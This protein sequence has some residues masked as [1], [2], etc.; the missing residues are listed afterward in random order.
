MD[1][2]TYAI[3]DPEDAI[4]FN[5]IEPR[6]LSNGRIARRFRSA[7]PI[8]VRANPPERFELLGDG[9]FGQRVILPV[10]PAAAPDSTSID[11]AGDGLG[12]D[13]FVNLA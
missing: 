6:K 8:E 13:I 4:T 7:A 5:A 3:R 2:I 11:P 9:P 10:L 1:E 12:A